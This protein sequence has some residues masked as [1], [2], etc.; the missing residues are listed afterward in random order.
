[1][2]RVDLLRRIRENSEIEM[3]DDVSHPINQDAA[4]EWINGQ[5]TLNARLIALSV[6]DAITYIPYVTFIEQ[7]R[8]MAIV[9]QEKLDLMGIPLILFFGEE[10]VRKS[11]FWCTML[12]L[13]YIRPI[14]VMTSER[15]LYRKYRDQRVAV[16]IVDDAAYSGQQLD[17]AFGVPPESPIIP[18]LI[19]PYVSDVALARLTSNPRE[20]DRKP[21]TFLSEPNVVTTF[22]PISLPSELKRSPEWEMF[23]LTRT[24]RLIYFDH[25]LADDVSVPPEIFVFGIMIQGDGSVQYRPFITGCTSLSLEQLERFRSSR[26][27]RCPTAFYKN[28][29]WMVDADTPIPKSFI[30]QLFRFYKI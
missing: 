4:S 9:T 7:L 8:R 13:D 19:T 18:V 6:L 20:G 14:D 28:I 3:P 23:G 11:N 2:N 27:D 21:Y 1:M 16:L 30:S 22:N 29:K 15:D 5:G 10:D 12:I 25:K 26:Y 17:L 24:S